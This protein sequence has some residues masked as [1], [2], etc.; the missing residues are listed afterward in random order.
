VDYY[1]YFKGKF[2]FILKGA[3]DQGAGIII[4]IITTIPVKRWRDITTYIL[5]RKNGR[6]FTVTHNVM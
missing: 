3:V 4:I 6:P 1:Q 5:R 2:A